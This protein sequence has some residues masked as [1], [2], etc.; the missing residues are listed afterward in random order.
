MDLFSAEGDG[1]DN[2][3][4]S[5]LLRGEEI[6]CFADEYARLIYVFADDAL[7]RLL[8]QDNVFAKNEETSLVLRIENAMAYPSIKYGKHE[9]HGDEYY[10]A[11]KLSMHFHRR[12]F[13]LKNRWLRRETLEALGMGP[14]GCMI[15][16][17]SLAPFPHKARQDLLQKDISIKIDPGAGRGRFTTEARFQSLP[18]SDYS[19][20]QKDFFL[21]KDYANPQFIPLDEF[22]DY[23]KLTESQKNYFIF[24]RSEFRKGRARETACGYILLYTRELLLSMNESAQHTLNELFRLRETYRGIYPE[25]FDLFPDWLLDFAVIN[26]AVNDTSF[27]VKLYNLSQNTK[28]KKSYLLF[29]LYLHKKYIEDNNGPQAADFIPIHSLPEEERERYEEYLNKSDMLLR[30]NY[31]KKLLEI[32][33]PVPFARETFACFN[34]LSGMGYSSYT[35][36]WPS[37]SSHKPLIKMLSSLSS[38]IEFY[39]RLLLLDIPD[40]KLEAVKLSR[41]REE[42]NEVMEMLKTDK[43]EEDFESGADFSHKGGMYPLRYTNESIKTHFSMQEFIESLDGTSLGCLDFISRGMNN[44]ADAF[45]RGNKT[46]IEFIIDEIN[47][48]FL[49]EKGDLLIENNPD[50]KFQIREE[51][52][53]EVIWALT[54]RNA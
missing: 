25:A 36:E 17:V 27:Y 10:S 28:T 39:N 29:D 7:Y 43:Y 31:G 46:M 12:Y 21:D 37:F 53:D 41:L 24:W 11:Y 23:D 52:R 34:G 44:E 8:G 18:A 3:N 35:A 45:A 48:Q 32:F 22:T 1:P 4:R 2:V 13:P 14:L 40:R 15:N 54:F 5:L 19:A 33:Y 30:K 38:V 9:K 42:S 51:Y 26:K 16:G 47:R 49:G 6:P 50:E 20:E